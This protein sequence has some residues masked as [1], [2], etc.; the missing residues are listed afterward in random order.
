LAAFE[1]AHNDF[2][3][4]L[5]KNPEVLNA[6]VLLGFLQV[7]HLG[8]AAR[9][10]EQLQQVLNQDTGEGWVLDLAE[11]IKRMSENDFEAALPPL[12]RALAANSPYPLEVH[13]VRVKA[14][15]R[16][17]RV[18][19][20]LESLNA[21]VK[22]SPRW[23]PAL[24]LRGVLRLMMADEKGGEEDLILAI[25]C[26]PGEPL[27]RINRGIRR[28][29]RGDH[30]GAIDDLT[31]VLDQDPKNVPALSHRGRAYL[32]LGD[33]VA[34]CRDIDK[35]CKLSP[36]DHAMFSN[37]A[38]AHLIAGN[39]K[40]A[41]EAAGQALAIKEDSGTARVIIALGLEA[42]GKHHEARKAA[43]VLR[44]SDPQQ[45][46]YIQVHWQE[47]N[48]C[49]RKAGIKPL[50]PSKLLKGPLPGPRDGQ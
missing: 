28:A 43:Q 1:A 6:R 14:L 13:W 33:P 34:A 44:E 36:R 3:Q 18:P 25:Q 29:N 37:R 24:A 2:K 42:L 31:V 8:R 27:A 7:M 12:D 26:D 49:R 5:D 39:L 40:T 11:G 45:A 9:G 50:S 22:L 46:R 17:R 16:L 20:A 41:I 47:V 35:S 48:R 23:A 38:M 19:E 30:R 15:V 10:R 21:V 32:D 4:A